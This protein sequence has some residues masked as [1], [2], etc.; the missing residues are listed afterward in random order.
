ME[1]DSGDYLPLEVI[2]SATISSLGQHQCEDVFEALLVKHLNCLAE[3][4]EEEIKKRDS[5]GQSAL[6]HTAKIG[7]VELTK[8]LLDRAPHLR[9]ATSSNGETAAHIAAAHGDMK[10]MEL[11]LGGKLRDALKPAMITDIN[12]T[13]VLMAAVARGDNEMAMWLLQ[14]FGKALAMLPNKC[15]MLPLHVAAAQGNLEFARAA[16][17]F[18]NQMVNFRDDFGCTPCLY[19]VQGGCLNTSRYL[20]EKARGEMACV[21]T[22][23]Q[24]LLH[25][26]ALCGHAHLV[27]WIMHR[28]GSEAILWTT[29]DRANAIHCAAFS[30]SVPVL[31]QLLHSF[32][33]KKRQNILAL[34]D[35]RGNTPLHLSAMN[36][37]LD[38]VIYQIDCGADVRL[39]NLKGHSAQSIAALRGFKDMERILSD[40]NPA[41]GKKKKRSKKSR[42]LHDLQ[43]TTSGSRAHSAQSPARYTN[44]SFNSHREEMSP[45]AW[46]SGYS[47][48][49]DAAESIQS[50]TAIVRHRLRY[51]EDGVDSL[52][53]AGAQTDTDLLKDRVKV[54]DDKTFT[55]LGLSALEQL[56]RVLADCELDD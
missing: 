22:K 46:S 16:T 17:K 43:L 48:N 1:E 45:H 56:D 40:H 53:D 20:V 52:R 11:L 2:E 9:D 12:G 31:A 8:Y 27:R 3:L 49:G 50:E 7:D 36:N 24:S 44:V 19:A 4:T 25:I 21:S 30:G 6:H 41:N 5:L 55:G 14:R 13:S 28:M 10:V 37:H 26:A 47:S 35:S 23:G 38:A 33:K 39:I 42:S 54:I 15:K 51:V 18:D 34:R 32:G 29:N